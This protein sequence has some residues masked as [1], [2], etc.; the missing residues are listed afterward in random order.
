MGE[1]EA[2]VGED[3]AWR[4]KIGMVKNIENVC[5]EPE[6]SAL[7]YGKVPMAG[8]VELLEMK[9]SQRIAARIALSGSGSGARSNPTDWTAKG[10]YDC[11]RRAPCGRRLS[12]RGA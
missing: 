4:R 5:L 8:E 9:P 1:T 7:A 10:S 12:G 6:V 11:S 3:R 2:T